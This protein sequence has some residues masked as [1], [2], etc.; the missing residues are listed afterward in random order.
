M[1]S[2]YFE[3]ID[4]EAQILNGDNC[5]YYTS[6]QYNSS[7]F[8]NSFKQSL[9]NFN[10]RS[11]HANLEKFECFLS[12][13]ASEFDFISLSETWN[14]EQNID[15]CHIENYVGFHTLRGANC[16]GGG[17]SI[18]CLKKYN[19]EKIDSL[20]FCNDTIESCAVK[21]SANNKT[22]LIICV[23]R[24]HR[25]P[26]DLFTETVN[27]ILQSP[28]VRSC[29]T[30]LIVG[31]M[32]INLLDESGSVQNFMAQLNSLNF[33]P[34]ITIPTRF[35]PNDSSVPTLLDHIL[36]NRLDK[37]T[38]GVLNIDLTDHCPSFIHFLDSDGEAER[39]QK[40]K[41]VFR[42]I[43]Q[44]GKENLEAKLNST[45]WD[46]LINND[47]E[48]SWN[49]FITYINE[50]YCGCFPKKVKYILNKKRDKPWINN[51][52]KELLKQKSEYFGL[53]RLGLISRTTNNRFKNRVNGMVQKS[54]KNYYKN[55]FEN[56]SRNLKKTWKC[57]NELMCRSNRKNEIKDMVFDGVSYGSSLGIAE[58]FN[59]FFINIAKKLDNELP[60]NNADPLL[61]LPSPLPNSF[62]LFDISEGE[63]RK[64]IRNLKIVSTDLNTMPVKLFKEYSN[65]FV[66]PL[67]KLI[68]LSYASGVFPSKLKIARVTPIF[69]SGDRKNPSN[70]RPI[71]NLSYISKILERSLHNRIA[72]FSNKYSI[73]TNSQYGFRKHFSTVDAILDLSESIY[74]SID[75]N[76][77]HTSVF[78]DLRKA[79]DTVNHDFLLNK[80]ISYG[81]R[82]TPGKL[83]KSFL[84]DRYQ[85]V[86]IDSYCSTHQRLDIG[87]PQGSILGPL[88]FLFYINDIQYA[89]RSSKAVLFADDTVISSNSHDY[90]DL[91]SKLN[92]D[93][94]SLYKWTL[95][96]RLSINVSKTSIICFTTKKF[97]PV[98]N[99]FAL[100]NCVLG[101]D[102]DCRYLG[103]ILDNEISFKPHIDQLVKKISRSTGIFYRIKDF[104]SPPARINFYYS[105]FYPYL[106]Y[107]IAIWGGTYQTYLKNLIIQQKRIVR[108]ITNSNFRQPT[109]KLFHELGLLK[110]H[111]IY[112]FSLGVIMYKNI[113][114]GHF[115]CAHSLNTRSRHLAV[116]EF[117][118][119]SLTQH[120][121][122]FSGP[123]MWNEIPLE[124]RTSSSL[125][126]F[127]Q[128]LKKYFISL[129]EAE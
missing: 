12:T 80:L 104:L 86:E 110:L 14:N 128:S 78:I 123:S 74:N 125:R 52:L 89:C 92:T 21:V 71:A 82:G 120:A 102:H 72:K 81:V 5:K 39:I 46:S 103:V 85:Y 23:Y 95:C 30:T 122:S 2:E 70:Y 67:C 118:R 60:P 55:I 56:C 96:N 3:N 62:H 44:R 129:Y 29:D 25:N 76:M 108:L 114:S 48:L 45:N 57:I 49:R 79:F 50:S 126:V 75:N 4:P 37:F 27:D 15:L 109:T 111:D 17:V 20:S 59:E 41:V 112:K 16:R 68:N 69:K 19:V 99:S 34:T 65:Y 101:L 61:S 8:S 9:I 32:N 117:H 97:P 31:D 58:K 35:S 88:L 18:F 42:P 106:A 11:F 66:Y 47:T 7:Y 73:L 33:L 38:S 40:Q 93:L 87:V 98:R 113:K 53:F 115:Q 94:D 26:I 124:I 51:N 28:I 63:C 121:F 91:V 36:I 77:F 6:T 10:I 100:N 116:P 107:C 90:N 54:R 84:S 127:K 105:F 22:L 83:I 119:L 13:L 64:L 24:P 1:V 43:F